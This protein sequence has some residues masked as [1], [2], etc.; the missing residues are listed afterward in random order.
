MDDITYR[1]QQSQAQ[2]SLPPGPG[3]GTGAGTAPGPAAVVPP[4]ALRARRRRPAVIL[5]AVALIAAGA[6]GG[7]VLYQRTGQ[8]VSVLALARDVPFGQKL[9]AGDLT[10]A[11]ISL[12]PSLDPVGAASFDK[13]LTMRATTDLKKGTILTKSM[14]TGQLVRKPGQQVVPVGAKEGQLPAQPLSPGQSVIVESTPVNSQGDE[15]TGK[16]YRGTVVRVGET[17]VDGMTVV[18]VAVDP[19]IVDQL[20]PVVSSGK[21]LVVIDTASGR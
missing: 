2:P 1:Q 4:K 19:A 18:D 13:A 10:E 12:D 21:F 7:A 6:L 15:G 20:A 9:S 8:R 17:T 11:Q 3:T 16:A 14:L 5:L